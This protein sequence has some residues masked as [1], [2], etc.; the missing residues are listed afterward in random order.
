MKYTFEYSF[1]VWNSVYLGVLYF[2]LLN[3]LLLGVHVYSLYSILFLE[4]H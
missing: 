1:F 3:R 2:Y 4:E